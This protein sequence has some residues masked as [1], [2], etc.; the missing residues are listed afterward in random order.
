MMETEPEEND[1]DAHH[2]VKLNQ[3]HNRLTIQEIKKAL[4]KQGKYNESDFKCHSFKSFVHLIRINQLFRELKGDSNR[5]AA[6][7]LNEIDDTNFM[8]SQFMSGKSTAN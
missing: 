8:S 7:R 3:R 6:L 2:E 5:L 1:D 4:L